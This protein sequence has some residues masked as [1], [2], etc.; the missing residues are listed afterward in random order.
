MI[1]A[2]KISLVLMVSAKKTLP[3]K[4]AVIGMSRV[5]SITLLAPARTRILKNTIYAK[6][7]P[8]TDRAN[9]ARIVDWLG[10]FSLQGWSMNAT[11][12]AMIIV[13]QI[14]WQVAAFRGGTPTNFLRPHSAAKP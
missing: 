1:A 5:T 4:S 12:A 14:N 10:K 13:E 9:R 7:V 3:K 2:P 8:N 6:A 11:I